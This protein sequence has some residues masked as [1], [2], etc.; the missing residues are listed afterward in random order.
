M[1]T[2]YSPRLLFISPAML[3]PSAATAV[4]KRLRELGMLRW[5]MQ[6]RPAAVQTPMSQ[7]G[8]LTELTILPFSR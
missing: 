3:M 4:V 1:V 5:R 8:K 2:A 7:L 6:I